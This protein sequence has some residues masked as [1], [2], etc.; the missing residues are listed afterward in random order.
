MCFLYLCLRFSTR[1]KCVSV[2][3]SVLIKNFLFSKKITNSA[4]HWLIVVIANQFY[5]PAAE[6]IL[7][8]N[9]RFVP[10][11]NDVLLHSYCFRCQTEKRAVAPRC[12][13]RIHLDIFRFEFNRE[14]RNLDRSA[15]DQRFRCRSGKTGEKKFKKTSLKTNLTKY[16]YAAHYPKPL[17][18]YGRSTY[19][20]HSTRV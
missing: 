15:I 10:A 16:T 3:L 2:T 8:T 14:I 12:S 19:W 4:N 20:Q 6:P 17:E 11:T 18:I 7:K 13:V 1:V 9:V 5:V